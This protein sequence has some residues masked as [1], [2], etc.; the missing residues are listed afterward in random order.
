VIK[1]AGEVEKGASSSPYSGGKATSYEGGSK[2]P[3]FIFYPEKIPAGT[4]EGYSQLW[5]FSVA[6]LH[7][8]ALS[9]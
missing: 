7:S 9:L 8:V 4:Y 3:A 1:N 5:P 2:V 6:L